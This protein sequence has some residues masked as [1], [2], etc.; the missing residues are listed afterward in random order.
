MNYW[1]LIRQEHIMPDISRLNSQSIAEIWPNCLLIKVQA[2]SGN[3]R[4]Y[5]Y[6]FMGE[7]IRHAYGKDMTGEFVNPAVRSVP[8]S[9]I[10]QKMDMV[11]EQ[12]APY[13]D[14]GQF[15]NNASKIVKYRSCMVPFGGLDGMVT[16]VLVGISW[17][18]F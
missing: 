18:A 5:Q 2:R 9:K 16:H 11:I 8:G 15:V 10:L 1:E 3:S 7:Q 12:V 6:D 17:R 4:M 13:Y 14:E